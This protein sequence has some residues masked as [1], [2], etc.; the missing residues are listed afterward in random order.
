VEEGI[1]SLREESKEEGKRKKNTNPG[2]ESLQ[3]R[4]SCLLPKEESESDKTR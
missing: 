1:E 2:I 4:H 3:R